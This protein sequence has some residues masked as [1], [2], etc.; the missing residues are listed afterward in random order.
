MKAAKSI[1]LAAI[2]LALSGCASISP[3]QMTYLGNASQKMEVVGKSSHFDFGGLDATA[4]KYAQEYN[5]ALD[6]AFQKAPLGTNVLKNIK[7]LKSPNNYPTVF[8][9]ALLAGGGSLIGSGP[10]SGQN[11]GAAD[12]RTAGGIFMAAV[13]LGFTMVNSYDLL[14]FGEPGT[15]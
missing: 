4:I 12:Q 1:P 15:E 11:G 6:D 3:P 2:L 8:G 14:V 10:I 5:A 7:V 9:L 13:G